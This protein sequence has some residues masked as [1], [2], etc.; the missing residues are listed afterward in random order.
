MNVL[1]ADSLKDSLHMANELLHQIAAA[2]NRHVADIEL[3]KTSVIQVPDILA[4][5]RLDVEFTSIIFR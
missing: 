2:R 4:Q 5:Q 3:Q 1:I